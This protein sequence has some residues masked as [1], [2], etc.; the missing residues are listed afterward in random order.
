M[1]KNDLPRLTKRLEQLAEVYGGKAPSA[2]G[3][4]VWMDAL[5]EVSIDDVEWCLTEWPKTASRTPNP[6]DVLKA[7]RTRVSDRLEAQGKREA[8]LAPTLETIRANSA[9]SPNARA[10]WRMFGAMQ[11]GK[12]TG[13][14]DWCARVLADDRAGSELQSFADQTMRLI[15]ERA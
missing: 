4:L 15:E 14:K 7:C 11:K 2:Q 5:G 10:F 1:Q 13:P 12:V 8:A 6:A 3:V 9:D